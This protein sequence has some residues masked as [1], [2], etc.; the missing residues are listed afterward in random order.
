MITSFDE[1]TCTLIGVQKTD[2]NEANDL[3]QKVKGS[4]AVIEN[5]SM[6]IK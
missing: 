5:A 6:L 1:E 2:A 4:V 3:I